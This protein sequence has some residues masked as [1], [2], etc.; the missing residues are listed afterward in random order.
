MVDSARPHRRRHEPHPS[1]RPSDCRYSPSRGRVPWPLT[2][3]GAADPAG[4]AQQLQGLPGLPGAVQERHGARAGRDQRG[5]RRARPAAGDRVARRQRQPRR[6]GA[7][8][9]GTAVPRKGRHADGDV[10]VER[11]T[12]GG[13]PRQAAQGAVPGRGA[14]DR[15]DRLGQR[16][17][18]HVPAAR[19]D[20][21]ADGDAR[22]GGGE[23]REE[24]LGDHLPQLRIRAIG[25]RRVQEADDRAAGG[26][27]R[28][29]R[30][31]CAA[32]QDRPGP[33]RAG[34]ARREARCDL[35]VAVRGRPRTLRPRRRAARPVQ[36]P[37]G[38]QSAGRRTRV[39]RPAEGRGARR[40]VGDRLSVVRDRD[41]GAQA[42]PRGLS[43]EIQRLSAPR[44]RRRLQH[45]AGC[46][47]RD[48]EGG[49][50]RH[51]EAHRRDERARV[52]VAVRQDHASARSTTSRRWARTS[53]ARR[54]RTARA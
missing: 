44:V 19:V 15:Q 43:G 3:D 35:L 24:A 13:G 21:H 49:I 16:Q 42:L 10:R 41:A 45:G 33:G 39:P 5:G 51:R 26:R 27:H 6:C 48:P 8:G 4:R 34:A 46:R 18:L 14:A 53:A 23:A 11:R 2:A 38:V 40:L 28:I 30:A 20:V 52:R 29:R 36:G 32:R 9:R 50:D 7:R 1:L 47:R 54:S 37:T 31:G 22:A 25:D 17:P 12:R